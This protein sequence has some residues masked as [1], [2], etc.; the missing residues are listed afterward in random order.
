VRNFGNDFPPTDSGYLRPPYWFIKW[1]LKRINEREK[2]PFTFWITPWEIDTKE[3]PL[4]SVSG[5]AK[6]WYYLSLNDPE[7][8]LKKLLGD[9]YFSTIQTLLGLPD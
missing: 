9:F 7:T 4:N 2:R 3:L 8:K 5:L 6:L 1:Q